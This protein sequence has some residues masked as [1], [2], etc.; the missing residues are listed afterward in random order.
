[1]VAHYD[2]DVPVFMATNGCS[3]IQ[4]KSPMAKN[5]QITCCENNEWQVTFSY[6]HDWP[7]YVTEQTIMQTR[8]C[9]AGSGIQRS[10]H[11]KTTRPS[12]T[13]VP[14][15][16]QPRFHGL[17]MDLHT[18]PGSRAGYTWIYFFYFP[19]LVHGHPCLFSIILIIQNTHPNYRANGNIDLP[20]SCLFRSLETARKM[21]E[22]RCLI[23]SSCF[24]SGLET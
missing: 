3:N 5:H 15:L 4:L 1:M 19:S 23:Q 20:F 13:C 22:P 7:N 10:T 11:F 21:I 16:G 17:T 6:L 24:Q 18:R 8:W 12:W 9:L 14:G 2:W